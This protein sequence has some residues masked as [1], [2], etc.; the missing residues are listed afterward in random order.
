M[1]KTKGKLAYYNFTHENDDFYGLMLAIKLPSLYFEVV[2]QYVINNMFIS[3]RRL[4]PSYRKLLICSVGDS[5]NEKNQQ[6]I[7]KAEVAIEITI[8]HIS[9]EVF[10]KISTDPFWRI[11]ITDR[12]CPEDHLSITVDK[13]TE[14][15]TKRNTIRL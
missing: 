7:M 12:D 13:E 14:F 10:S 2:K 5:L 15:I 9:D 6:N 8:E 11:L 1:I 3:V 4:A